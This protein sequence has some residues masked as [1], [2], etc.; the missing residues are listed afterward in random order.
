MRVGREQAAGTRGKRS[1]SPVTVSPTCAGSTVPSCVQ[2]RGLSPSR[3]IQGCRSQVPVGMSEIMRWIG[4]SAGNTTEGIG[5]EK[6]AVGG[7]LLWKELIF[8][9][10]IVPKDSWAQAV[11]RGRLCCPPC[12]RLSPKVQMQGKWDVLPPLSTWPEYGENDGKRERG[13]RRQGTERGGKEGGMAGVGWEE[14]R[15]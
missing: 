9:V 13:E 14:G 12:S 1:S 5:H 4:T 11:Y 8:R 15:S 6:E 7:Y 3:G 10:P 2:A